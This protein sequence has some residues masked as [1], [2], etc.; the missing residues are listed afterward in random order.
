MCIIIHHILSLISVICLFQ[1]LASDVNER[2]RAECAK[3]TEPLI[4]AVEGLTT[5]ASSPQFA[6]TPAK[7][8]TQARVAQ[9][10]IIAV[11]LSLHVH[12]RGSS[13]LK[14]SRHIVM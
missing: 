11:S 7:I 10:P 4:K 5:F 3:A 6:S 2:N 14:R 1:I 8:S 9:E 13:W 12:V